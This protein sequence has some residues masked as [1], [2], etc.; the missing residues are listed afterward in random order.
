MRVQFSFVG[1][2]RMQHEGDLYVDLDVIPRVGDTVSVP[3]LSQGDTVVRTVVW[4]PFGGDGFA[5]EDGP[6]V[7]V[8]L[9]GPR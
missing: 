5:P 3:G 7:Y 9:G 4:Y 1:E 2:A 6:S 8:V